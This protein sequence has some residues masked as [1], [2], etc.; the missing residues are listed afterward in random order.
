MRIVCS[1]SPSFASALRNQEYRG[2][3]PMRGKVATSGARPPRVVWLP[4]SIDQE[5][6]RRERES[7]GDYLY[8]R[9][10]FRSSLWKLFNLRYVTTV[11]PWQAAWPE[12]QVVLKVRRHPL[13]ELPAEP[14]HAAPGDAQAT[15]AVFRALARL[16]QERFGWRTVG[17]ILAAQV[18]PEVD[19][20]GLEGGPRR[21]PGDRRSGRPPRRD[22]QAGGATSDPTR[23]G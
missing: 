23:R 8:L 3:S 12:A 21:R 13:L 14:A 19:R 9:N 2:H 16:A 15:A 11:T 22:H 1:R 4:A 18:R 7:S 6:F 5:V 10:D 20:S 17:E